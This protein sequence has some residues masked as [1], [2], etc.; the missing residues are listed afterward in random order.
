MT[1]AT[2]SQNL[3]GFEEVVREIREVGRGTSRTSGL[4]NWNQRKIARC[5]RSLLPNHAL[6]PSDTRF[7][8]LQAE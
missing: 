7:K 1:S 4:G 3:R 5:A 8:F 6:R 2:R